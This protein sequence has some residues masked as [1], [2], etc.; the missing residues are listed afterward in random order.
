M[1]GRLTFIWFLQP[2]L[3]LSCIPS[4]TCPLRLFYLRDDAHVSL[5][6]VGPIFFKLV[7]K[8]AHDSDLEFEV[9]GEYEI[10]YAP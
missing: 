4:P 2:N 1:K 8:E 9:H 5:L 3:V 10:S 6:K 7:A